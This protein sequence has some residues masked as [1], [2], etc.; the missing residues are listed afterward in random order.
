MTAYQPGSKL[1]SVPNRLSGI[2]TM[3]PFTS[4][5]WNLL[6]MSFSLNAYIAAQGAASQPVNIWILRAAVILWEVAGPFTLLVA[7]VIRYAIWPALLRGKRDTAGLKHWRNVMMHNMNALFAVSE[8][9]LFGGLDVKWS[10]FAFGPL[11]GAAYVLF[12]W[13]MV[14]QWN[15][16]EHGPQYIYFFFDTTLPG[17]KTTIALLLLLLTL[18]IFYGI[19]W[20]CDEI[21]VLLGKSVWTHSAF[22]AVV[23]GAV[24]R[25]K[26]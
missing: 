11:V 13:I 15:K 14:H 9:A 20:I 18:T 10:H 6:G 19:F 5:S 2:K 25:F 7:A 3:M 4:L 12:S 1:I 17:Y 8:A 21:L 24:M 26:D 23:C 16:P 22:V